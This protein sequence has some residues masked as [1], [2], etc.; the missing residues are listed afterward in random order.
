M[1]R[2]AAIRKRRDKLGRSVLGT[3]VLASLAMTLQPCAVAGDVEH[4]CPHCPP[5]MAHGA[6][7]GEKQADT[8]CSATDLVGLEARSHQFKSDDVTPPVPLLV[9]YTV[10]EFTATGAAGRFFLSARRHYPPSGPPLCI[11]NCVFLK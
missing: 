4:D 6:H 5:E 7:H 11:L 10:S 1:I 8:E 2:L 9:P 3:F